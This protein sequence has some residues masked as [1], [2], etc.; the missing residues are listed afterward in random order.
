MRSLYYGT[1]GAGVRETQKKLN[2]AGASLAVDGIWGPKTEQAYQKYAG[3]DEAE[4]T[5]AGREPLKRMAYAP[6]S[7]AQILEA[8]RAQTEGHYAARRT[9]ETQKAE[10]LQ[11]AL[12]K[13]IGGLD[14]EYKQRLD[15]LEKDWAARK[16]SAEQLTLSRGMG[17]SSHALDLQAGADKEYQSEQNRTLSEKQTKAQELRDKAESIR[18]E[19][20][21]TLAAL[22]EAQGA[23]ESKAAASLKGEREEQLEKALK[24]NNEIAVKEAEQQRKQAEWE[25]KMK[26]AAGRSSSGGGHSTGT[27]KS[28]SKKEYELKVLSEWNGMD[29]KEKKAYFEKNWQDLYARS[30]AA[31]KAMAADME[32]ITGKKYV[33]VK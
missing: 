27:G 21:Q 32:K 23:E 17:R 19:L 33:I 9:D 13:A 14:P 7:D 1:R 2:E 28:L 10:A 16:K 11:Q 25:M 24:Y 12:E 3:A 22:E 8:A 4:E 30:P 15:A 31:A 26:K 20:Q 6:L 29:E 5:E 18:K